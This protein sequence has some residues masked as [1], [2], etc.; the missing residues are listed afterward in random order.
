MTSLAEQLLEIEERAIL[1]ELKLSSEQRQTEARRRLSSNDGA[2]ELLYSVAGQIV[3]DTD[4]THRLARQ[5]GERLL[6]GFDERLARYSEQPEGGER[7][8]AA[9]NKIRRRVRGE[10]PV[11]WAGVEAEFDGSRSYALEWLNQLKSDVRSYVDANA[12]DTATEEAD[13]IV[14]AERLFEAWFR[15]QG[16]EVAAAEEAS[17]QNRYTKD[18][19]AA[20]RETEALED[21][22]ARNAGLQSAYWRVGYSLRWPEILAAW[23]CDNAAKAGTRNALTQL[24]EA[25]DSLA[26]QAKAE[27]RLVEATCDAIAS[28]AFTKRTAGL[29][30]AE[31]ARAVHEF[32]V[33]SSSSQESKDVLKKLDTASK[34]QS[35]EFTTFH[36]AR[37]VALVLWFDRVRNELEREKR[38]PP[39]LV[40]AVAMPV[41]RALSGVRTQEPNGQ[42][43]LVSSPDESVFDMALADV[44]ALKRGMIDKGI[45]RFG[46]T[47]AH[48]VLRHQI[49]T[50]HA[51]AIG[52]H[53]DPR[54]V[55]IEG[56]WGGYASI[57]GLKGGD[58][59][60]ALREIVE[61]QGATELVL[62]NG[63]RARMLSVEYTEA[64]RGHPAHL[65][66][67]LGTPLL[68]DYVFELQRA[69]PRG[70]NR[71]LAGRLVPILP[72]PQLFGRPN[73]HG[74]LATLSMMLVLHMR[75]HAVDLASYGGIILSDDELSSLARESGLKPDF[76]RT[77]IRRWTNDGDDAPAFLKLSESERFTLGDAHKAARDFLEMSGRVTLGARTGGQRAAEKRRLKRLAGK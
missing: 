1:E 77:A 8:E 42:L 67:I 60:T 56:G 22:K 10:L 4:I 54:L 55:N 5:M 20:L 19:L 64:K 33:P 71:D 73:E 53:P 47:I 58:K 46:S 40:Y 41:A 15:V 35:W 31:L 45:E 7:D 57:L 17:K 23:Q 28:D 6:V 49:F 26:G 39:A 16:N 43:M 65:R 38:K 29:A 12:G 72:I 3:R 21:E 32:L 9:R 37:A 34:H 18:A 2:V 50:G 74:K 63:T 75:E 11:A 66:L 24:R 69:L 44:D 61:A 51:Q 48:K 30:G 13:R 36:A 76:T 59:A 62:P 68:P 70:R 14:L 52:G 27:S 25:K